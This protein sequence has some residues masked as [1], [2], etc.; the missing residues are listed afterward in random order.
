MIDAQTV[1][2]TKTSG[3]MLSFQII[4]DGEGGY[5]GTSKEVL[6]FE[7]GSSGHAGKPAV[8]TGQLEHI[9][10]NTTQL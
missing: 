7:F 3:L 2:E 1:L 10:G 4:G 6:Y 8:C 5:Y 9:C